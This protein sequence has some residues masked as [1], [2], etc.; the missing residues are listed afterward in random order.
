MGMMSETER[1]NRQIK[2]RNGRMLGYA[3]YGA[4][5]GKPTLASTVFPARALIGLCLIRIIW[6]R[7]WALV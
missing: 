2:L 1:M 4:A 7:K 3:K 6:L 5:V